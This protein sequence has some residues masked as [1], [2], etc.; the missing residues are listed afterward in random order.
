MKYFLQTKAPA[1]NWV[2]NLGCAK[3]EECVRHGL[4]LRQVDGDQV[5]VI[6]RT[7]RV[8]WSGKK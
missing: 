7:D 6:E 3:K 5:R 2:D 4:W 1:G 8:V